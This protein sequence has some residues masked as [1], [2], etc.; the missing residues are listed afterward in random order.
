MDVESAATNI[1]Y[2]NVGDEALIDLT[3]LCKDCHQTIT[4]SLR[5]RKLRGKVF[6]NVIAKMPVLVE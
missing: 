5:R 3:T 1:N 2:D 6:D 4:R